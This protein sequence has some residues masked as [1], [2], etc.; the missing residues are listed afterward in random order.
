MKSSDSDFVSDNLRFEAKQHSIRT[1]LVGY[2]AQDE[3]ILKNCPPLVGKTEPRAGTL[4]FACTSPALNI[5]LKYV[6]W[7][8]F[9]NGTWSTRSWSLTTN[10]N[11]LV[12]WLNHVSPADR[13]LLEESFE[14]T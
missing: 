3:W 13:S 2:R 6:F 14:R 10:L 11:R 9:T 4:R 5:E 1:Q 8:K 12:S 7:Q